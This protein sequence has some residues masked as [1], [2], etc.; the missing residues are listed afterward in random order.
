MF[1]EMDVAEYKVTRKQRLA[2]LIDEATRVELQGDTLVAATFRLKADQQGGFKQ[3]WRDVHKLQYR[4]EDDTNERGF[5]PFSLEDIQY[6]LLWKLLDNRRYFDNCAHCGLLEH[7][8]RLDKG[9]CGVCLSQQVDPAEGQ[10]ADFIQHYLKPLTQDTLDFLN[11]DQ[12]LVLMGDVEDSASDLAVGIMWN[13]VYWDIHT[14]V[15]QWKLV[16]RF[17]APISVNSNEMHQAL[18]K[19][20]R[21]RNYFKTC[22]SCGEIQP[23]AHIGGRVCYSCMEGTG[24]CF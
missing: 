10:Q 15:S 12:R 20:V 16:K 2:K 6:D 22:V 24:V 18:V 9:V 23:L 7:V 8:D 5:S 17:D 19:L 13:D 4:G 11:F 1:T 3:Q 14:P 21:N